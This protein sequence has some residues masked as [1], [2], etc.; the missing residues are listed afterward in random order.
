MFSRHRSVDGHLALDMVWRS[1]QSIRQIDE[2]RSRHRRDSCPSDEVVGGFFFDFEAVRTTSR[3]SAQVPTEVYRASDK[4]VGLGPFLHQGVVLHHSV[5]EEAQ[6]R[7]R[8]GHECFSSSSV[9]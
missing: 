8:R 2:A 7:E 6:F 9:L 4:A 3:C 5:V 1:V